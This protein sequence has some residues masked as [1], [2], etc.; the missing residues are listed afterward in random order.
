M[1]E[2]L[3]NLM[4]GHLTIGGHALLMSA[5]LGA[6]AR[7]ALVDPGHRWEHLP[8]LELAEQT[9]YP[10]LTLA[11]GKGKAETLPIDGTGRQR[12]VLDAPRPDPHRSG[13]HRAKALAAAREGA[14]VLII[15]NTVTSAQAVFTSVLEHGGA[16]L[17]LQAG[18]TDGP[19]LPP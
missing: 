12:A 8:T 6:A 16:S 4:Q 13:L 1:T 10:A 2:L 17:V 3:R 15:R 14:K 19:A 9:P 7:T 5:T 11:D 18:P